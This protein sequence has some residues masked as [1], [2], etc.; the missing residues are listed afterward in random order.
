MKV[1]QLLFGPLIGDLLVEITQDELRVFSFSGDAEY[2]DEPVVA[3]ERAGNK[4]TVKAIGKA[5]RN[6]PGPGVELIYPFKHRRSMISSF[7]YAEQVLRF[8]FKS[9]NTNLFRASP[10]V[11]MHQLERNEGGLTEVEERVLRE[12]AL[13][14]GAREVVVYQG[15]RIDPGQETFDTIK[16]RINAD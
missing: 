6:C 12:L 1:L 14:A 2:I 13:G 5:S 16:S 4:T 15:D 11:V 8:A 10:R 9:I 7:N 3:I